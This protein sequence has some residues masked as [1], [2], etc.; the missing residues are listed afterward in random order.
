[1]KPHKVPNKKPSG[2][3]ANLLQINQD[4][5]FIYSTVDKKLRRRAIHIYNQMIDHGYSADDALKFITKKYI[6]NKTQEEDR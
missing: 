2:R 3:L 1:M 6:E 5:D 4:I